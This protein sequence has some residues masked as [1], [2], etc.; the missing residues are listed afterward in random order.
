MSGGDDWGYWSHDRI[1]CDA[2]FV[3]VFLFWL[4]GGTTQPTLPTTIER[5]NHFLKNSLSQLGA[6]LF[7]L[8]LSPPIT[9]YFCF[10]HRLRPSLIANM[11]GPQRPTSGLPTRR[12]TTRQPTRRAGSVAPERQA[13]A[14]SPA[15]ST[16]AP[17]ASRLRGLKSPTEPASIS[18]K[19]KER[20]I[21]REINEDTSIHV[22]VRCRGRNEREVKENSGVALQTEGVK[23]KTVELSMGPNAVSNKTY[24]FD[25]V[26]S[27]AADQV[28]VYE[29]SVL[30]IVTEVGFLRL[31]VEQQQ[32]AN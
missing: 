11:A 4:Q 25:K 30:P 2:R 17:A 19:R 1:C 10:P 21:E 8:D 16:K 12:T 31:Q 13:S 32:N 28:T 14:P 3:Y 29:D 9:L 18:A 27:A 26:F 6:Y 5:L 7:Y 20:D 24:T 22:V 15:I 23:G